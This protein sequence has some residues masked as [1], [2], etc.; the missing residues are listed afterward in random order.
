MDGASKSQNDSKKSEYRDDSPETMKLADDV[1]EASSLLSTYVAV[2]MDDLDLFVSALEEIRVKERSLAGRVRRWL[3]SLFEAI[4]KVIAT[5][6]PVISNTLCTIPLPVTIG[7]AVAFTVLGN[8]ASA[9]CERDS[10]AL[11]EHIVLPLQGQK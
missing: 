8:A 6:F 10:G 3:K 4:A 2:M 1:T 11:L 7:C 9:I 5:I